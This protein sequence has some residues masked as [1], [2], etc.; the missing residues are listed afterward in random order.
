MNVEKFTNTYQMCTSCGLCESVFGKE[1]IQLQ[2]SRGFYFPK[3]MAKL[4]KED[5]SLFNSICPAINMEG[6]CSQNE[7]FDPIIGSYIGYYN[8]YSADEYIRWK[9]STGGGITSFSNFLLEEKYVDGIL[10]IGK[11]STVFKAEASISK[12]VDEIIE[13]S[14][15]QYM[16]TSLLSDILEYLKEDQIIAIIGKPC[17][18][19]AVNNLLKQFPKYQKKIFVTISF[20]CG[21]IPSINSTYS[22]IE[23]LGIKKSAVS[24][25]KYRGEGW[26]GD[27]SVVAGNGEQKSVDYD[28]A[29]G[30]NLGRSVPLVCKICVDSVGEYADVVFGDAWESDDNGYP[31]FTSSNGNNLIITRSKKGDNLVKLSNEKG[32]LELKAEKVEQFKKIQ[33]SQTIRRS[34]SEQRVIALRFT[35]LNIKFD[36]KHIKSISKNKYSLVKKIRFTLGTFRRVINVRR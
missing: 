15:S 30:K 29:W 18:I 5:R 28:E 9:S 8:G 10:H 23:Q 12:T 20:L 31:V 19:R 33:P 17:D 11:G 21:G 34:T 22:L 35:Q 2:E 14:G 27:F 3:E 4:D 26:P 32:Y 24:K 13:K 36:L 6:K 7:L 25:L 16:P 1:K